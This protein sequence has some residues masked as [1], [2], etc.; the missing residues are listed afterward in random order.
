MVIDCNRVKSSGSVQKK[1]N[2]SLKKQQR[3]EEWR[4]RDLKKP[5]RDRNQ[6]REK[7]GGEKKKV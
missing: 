3:E 7:G 2:V 1:K 5:S 4:G 6:K